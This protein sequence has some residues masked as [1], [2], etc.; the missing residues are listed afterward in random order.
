M[1]VDT[2]VYLKS[3]ISLYESSGFI[4]CPPFHTVPAEISHTEVFMSQP[5]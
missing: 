4:H 3:A 5:L 2:A 1:L